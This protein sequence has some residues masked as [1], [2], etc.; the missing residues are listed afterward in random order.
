MTQVR[1]RRRRA[2]PW[3]GLAALLARAA[4]TTTSAPP[5]TVRVDRGIVATT[6]SASGK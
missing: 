4:C 6:V 5:P 1:G 2:V 3:V